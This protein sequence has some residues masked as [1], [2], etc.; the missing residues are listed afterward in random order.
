MRVQLESTDRIVTLNVNGVDVP[1]R[2]WQGETE[3]GVA[4]YAYVTRVMVSNADDHAEFER[5]LLEAVAPRPVVA[6]LP[7]RMVL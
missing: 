2:I 7:W 3:H 1:A 5:D 6:A 4:V